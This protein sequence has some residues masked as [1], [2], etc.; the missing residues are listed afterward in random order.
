VPVPA[1]FELSPLE[2]PLELVS[3]LVESPPSPELLLH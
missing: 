1:L 3:P 2:A